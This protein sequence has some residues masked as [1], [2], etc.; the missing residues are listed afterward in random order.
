MSSFPCSLCACLEV[1]ISNWS[2]S[3]CVPLD[4]SWTN[5][6]FRKSLKWVFR[7]HHYCRPLYYHIGKGEKM[8]VLVL[9]LQWSKCI[10]NNLKG[11]PRTFNGTFKGFYVPHSSQ[12]W[13]NKTKQNKN[14][15]QNK[16]KKKH[17]WPKQPFGT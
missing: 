12:M 11:T 2:W 13:K 8:K 15:K 7:P 4:P 17:I 1:L 5:V 16:T 14:I 3:K 10:P 6:P 9:F